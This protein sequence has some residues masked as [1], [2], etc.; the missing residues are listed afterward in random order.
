MVLV[1]SLLFTGNFQP[2]I[3]TVALLSMDFLWM[4]IV[5]GDVFC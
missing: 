5:R 2:W 4:F 3:V 1:S